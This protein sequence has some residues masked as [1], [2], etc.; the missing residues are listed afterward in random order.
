MRELL[1]LFFFKENIMGI[2]T[3]Q[4]V[5]RSFAIEL[6]KEKIIDF[7]NMPLKNDS[8]LKKMNINIENTPEYNP[9]SQ[10][11]LKD[12]NDN[13]ETYSNC[14][15]EEILESKEFRRSEYDNYRVQN[16]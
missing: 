10:E 1:A 12:L 14:I 2:Q 15:L 11:E 8:F 4:E 5:T 13:I 9:F 3:T 7:K 16:D 6:I